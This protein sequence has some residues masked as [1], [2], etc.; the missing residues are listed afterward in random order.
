MAKHTDA[1]AAGVESKLGTG[2]RSRSTCRCPCSASFSIRVR[3]FTSCVSGP[4][5]R[6]FWR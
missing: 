6:F 1:V 2:S 3:R 5:E 4:V